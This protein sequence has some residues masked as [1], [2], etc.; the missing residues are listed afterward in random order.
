MNP[1]RDIW[2]A[3]GVMAAIVLV[4]V[5]LFWNVPVAMQATGLVA[6]VVG[7]LVRQALDPNTPSMR[8]KRD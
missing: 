1:Y 6:L 5:V 8:R 2:I 7:F 4:G 3:S